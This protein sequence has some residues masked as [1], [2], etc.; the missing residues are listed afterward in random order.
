VQTITL[1]AGQILDPFLLVLA[2]EVKATQIGPGTDLVVAHGDL[3]QA[4]RDLFP[5]GFAAI[6]GVAAL[7][8]IA[9]FDRLADHHLAGVR[10]FL[11]GDQL[12]QSRFTGS[13]T[14][15]H[16]DDRALGNAKGQIFEQLF[17]AIGLADAM[18]L[19]DLFA[20]TRF[21]AS[22]FDRL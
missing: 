18:Q 3:V 20:Q 2:F 7:I 17:V 14:A 13:V 1:T 19:D 10:L 5:H 21:C 15:N 11:A 9:E 22:N 4:V 12:E 8:D 6:Q 16:A